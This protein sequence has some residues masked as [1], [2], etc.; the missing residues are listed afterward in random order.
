MG[1]YF[2]L[3]AAA[4]EPRVKRVIGSE[5]AFDYRKVARAL[6]PCS[7]RSSTITSRNLPTGC[8]DERSGKA[9]TGRAFNREDHAQN[10]CQIG[11][12]GLALQVMKEW[13]GTKTV[14][15]VA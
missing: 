1:G 7:S 14:G 5:H 15:E 6:P 3:T 10:H 4:F 13:I 8:P 2:A 11:N 12:I 9:V